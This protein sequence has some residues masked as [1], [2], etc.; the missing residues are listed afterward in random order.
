MLER[1]LHGLGSTA[2]TVAYIAG[3]MVFIG[4]TAHALGWLLT[5]RRAAAWVW[6]YWNLLG[7]VLLLAGLGGLGYGWFV[8]GLHSS[9]GSAL[10]GLGLLL[11]SAG[12]WMIVPI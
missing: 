11:A 7:A 5:R 6:G 1:V 10:A 3:L 2:S 9:A 4:A 8:L 12:L